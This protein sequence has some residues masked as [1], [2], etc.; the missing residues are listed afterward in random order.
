MSATDRLLFL[1][2]R[3]I[4]SLNRAAPATNSDSAFLENEC[5]VCGAE[6]DISPAFAFDRRRLYY[7]ESCYH[8]EP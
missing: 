1:F 5:V 7:C 3:L 4:A 2:A 8:S 6:F